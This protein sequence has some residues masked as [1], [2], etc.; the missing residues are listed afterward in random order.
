MSALTAKN[1]ANLPEIKDKMKEKE[2]REKSRENLLLRKEKVK[3]MDKV[4]YQF[5][6]I[7]LS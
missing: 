7:F 5:F 3:E 1:Y 6:S 4:D 2:K